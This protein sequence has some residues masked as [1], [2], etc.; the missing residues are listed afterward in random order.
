MPPGRG[1]TPYDA[2]RAREG[3]GDRIATLYPNATTDH[4]PF[5]ANPAAQAEIEERYAPAR[6]AGNPT[7]VGPG[8]DGVDRTQRLTI[9]MN[10]GTRRQITEAFPWTSAPIYLVRDNDGAYGHVFTHRLWTMGVRDQPISP[11]R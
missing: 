3:G 11:G 2:R 10:D 7:A 5:Q 9:D 8:P 4:Y 1:T 6:A